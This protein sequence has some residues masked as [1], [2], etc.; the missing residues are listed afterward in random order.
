M[1]RSAG[2]LHEFLPVADMLASAEAIVRVF[3]KLGDFQHKARNR[4][5]FLIK[6]IGWEGFQAEYERQLAD[7][8]A[9]GR[10]RPMS[11]GALVAGLGV[12][13]IMGGFGDRC[14]ILPG[15]G[16]AGKGNFTVGT[17]LAP[18]RKKRSAMA[19]DSR[20]MVRS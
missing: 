11:Y 6:S 20:M 17:A 9:A 4:M 13:G 1:C 7:V 18:C 14:L 8:F 19:F 5:K 16:C 2:P 12:S 10:V 15:G 3:H